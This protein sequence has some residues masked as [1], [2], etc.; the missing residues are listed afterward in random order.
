MLMEHNMEGTSV[1]YELRNYWV[2]PGKLDALNTRFRSL[3]LRMFERHGMEVVG[4]WTPE[5]STEAV[6]DLVYMLRFPD[7]AAMQRS[8]AAMRA[9]SEWLNGKAA[10]E[11]DGPLVDH[12]TSTLLT[13]TDYSPLS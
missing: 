3:T 4:F 13:P 6:G 2:A 5:A 9:D 11:V 12:L 8:W 7:T 10:S 1:I